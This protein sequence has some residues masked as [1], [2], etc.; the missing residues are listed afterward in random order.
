MYRKSVHT[1]FGFYDET[2]RAAGDTEFKN[3][4]L[5]FI[6]VSFVPR[7]LG[8]FLNYPDD[9]TTASPRAEI[10]DTR[11]WYIHR[12][13]GGIRYGFEQRSPEDVRR[14]LCMALGYRKSYSTRISSD[15]EYAK[16]LADYYLKEKPSRDVDA[17]RGDLTSLLENLRSLEW[18]HSPTIPR[19][20]GLS[21]ARMLVRAKRLQ[22]RHKKLFRG[23]ANPHYG[24]FNDNRYEQ[25]SW[26]WSAS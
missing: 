2:F 12:T 21:L 17:V 11:A 5:P 3:R 26:L 10:E 13:P 18:A 19:S 7:T 1:R 23:E 20:A 16:Y 14:L 25:H 15:V 4:V 8:L 9:R 6:S 22:R 24:I